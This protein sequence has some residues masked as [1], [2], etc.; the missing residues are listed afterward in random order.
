[1]EG[2]LHYAVIGALQGDQYDLIHKYENQIGDFH[3]ILPLIQDANTFEKCHALE[4]FCGVSCLLKH[5]TKYNM[6]PILQKY[7]EELSMRAYLHETLFELACLWQR[8][9]VLKWIEQTIHVYDL[10]IMFN[11]AISKRDL[12]MYSLGY[13]FLFDRGNTE[14]TLLT[15]HLKKTAAKGL[16]HFV[17]ETLK[18]G[19]NIDTVL[20][21]AVKYNHRKLLDYFLRQLP[22]KH[23]EKLLLLAVQE[24]ASKKTLNLLLSHLNYS[25]K[26]IKKL[27]R[28]VI[29]Y[30]STLV[31]KILLKKE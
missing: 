14:A 27:P 12:T 28:Y 8:Y 16:L 13:I 19:G 15:Q 25:V 17:L 22:R 6:L 31:I 4:R 23:I 7:Q 11:I 2:N 5:A 30:E 21:Q 20:T 18:Y 9:D 10:K 3:F 26:R 24:K 29:E 1:M